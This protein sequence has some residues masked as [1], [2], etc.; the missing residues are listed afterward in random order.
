[1]N[2]VWQGTSFRWWAWFIVATVAVLVEGSLRSS[3]GLRNRPLVLSACSDGSTEG[4]QDRRHPRLAACDGHWSGHVGNASTSLC[5]PGW[6]VCGSQNSELLRAVTWKDALSLNGC[7]AL[8]AGHDSDGRCR[9]CSA[10][11]STKINEKIDLAGV[12][13]SCPVRSP[14]KAS[15]ISGGRMDIAYSK[16]Q[17]DR[18]ACTSIPG[19]VTGVLCC[20]MPGDVPQIIVPPTSVTHV[21]VGGLFVLSCQ[22]VGFP[23]PRIAWLRD[24]RPVV[25]DHATNMPRR[26]AAFDSGYLIVSMADL[27]DSATYKCLATNSHGNVTASARVIVTEYPSG[28]ADGTTDGLYDYEEVQ[29]CRGRW[30]GHVRRAAKSLCAPGWQVCSPRHSIYLKMLTWTDV[31]RLDGCYAYNA[32]NSLN[33][34]SVCRNGDMAG[35]GKDCGRQRVGGGH[36]SCLAD[37]L[38]DVLVT[39][40]RNR[41]ERLCDYVEGRT[42]GVLCC[43]R[44]EKWQIGYHWS[45]PRCKPGCQNG[46]VCVADGLCRCPRGYKGAFC[47]NP[48]CP[49]G[50]IPNSVCVRPAMCRC[51]DGFTGPKCRSRDL[52]HHSSTASPTRR[53]SGRSMMSS[54]GG[55]GA[56]G[57]GSSSDAGREM[58]TGSAVDLPRTT[59]RPPPSVTTDAVTRLCHCLNG[60]RCV[61]GA[62]CKC[63]PGYHGRRCGHDVARSRPLANV[64]QVVE[65]RPE[66]NR[67]EQQQQ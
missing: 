2:T 49:G 19:L 35:V 26:V 38:I 61:D 52:P 36:R 15:C 62:A 37:G 9:P 4:L 48:I 65:L 56:A 63:P 42:T 31:T 17:V 20:R 30:S 12:G 28:C 23:E 47:Q 59:T 21:Q 6:T 5:A 64:G 46:G 40:P 44:P 43:R 16:D 8:N 25:T 3:A 10:A 55:R 67:T 58:T 14:G 45:S 50:C 57:N 53:S 18:P 54:T 66:I 39:Q 29:A 27:A 13:S 51:V 24:G 32:A 22:A 41:T 7:Y 34:C 33:L 1:M 60:G 11:D